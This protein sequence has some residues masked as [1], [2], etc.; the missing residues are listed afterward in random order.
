MLRNR[1]FRTKQRGVTMIGWIFL[2]IPM[3]MVGY[4]A[5]RLV[6][7]Y[8]NYS[9]VAKSLNQIADEAAGDGS[10]TAD[11]LRVA[12]NKRLD[13]ESIEYPTIKEFTIRKSGQVW[14]MEVAYEESIPYA[15]NVSLLTS[16]KKTVQV[17]KGS[18][19]E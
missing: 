11:T 4:A 10:A 5:I 3:A 13:I 14:I 2:L 9:R 16:F 8:L 19:G 17:G 1:S 18:I 6:P 7:V 15:Y 12:L